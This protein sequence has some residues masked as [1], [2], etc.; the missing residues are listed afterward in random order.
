MDQAAASW[1]D[2]Y[3]PFVLVLGTRGAHI[4]VLSTVLAKL[5]A[6]LRRSD[7]RIEDPEAKVSPNAC[8]FRIVGRRE[9]WDALQ[10]PIVAVSDG[11]AAPQRDAAALEAAYAGV[12]FAGGLLALAAKD[13][14]SFYDARAA[15]LAAHVPDDTFFGAGSPTRAITPGGKGAAAGG[16]LG[17][18]A[19]VAASAP[20]QAGKAASGAAAAG[21]GG[22]A[23]SGKS[24]KG[25]GS[26]AASAIPEPPEPFGDDPAV[27]AAAASLRSTIAAAVARWPQSEAAAGDAAARE[28]LASRG[29]ELSG[30]GSAGPGGGGGGAASHHASASGAAVAPTHV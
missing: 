7:P 20:K 12:D 10:A 14:R 5:K 24:S 22:G 1:P 15:A 30:S 23:G 4:P 29:T 2:E 18:Q 3:R 16:R 28:G 6:T 13:A 25:G 11:E 9:A 8:I 17:R 19:S 27:I 21:G 26:G